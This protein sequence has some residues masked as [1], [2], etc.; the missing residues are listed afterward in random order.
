M[1]L[2][3]MIVLPPAE[4]FAQREFAVNFNYNITSGLS[5]GSF[6]EAKSDTV[7]LPRK[8]MMRSVILPGWGQYTNRQAWKIPIVYG[9]LGGLS[10]YAYFA[11]TRYAGYRAA[12][13]N[14]FEVN[15]D[16]KFGQTPGWIDPNVS[17]DFLRT[18]RD[19]YRNRR[20]FLIVTVFLAYV[21]NFVD[22]YVY[23]HMRDFDVSDDL[24][25]RIEIG[26]S[27]PVATQPTLGFTFKLN[28]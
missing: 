22:A 21:L 19:F 8:V 11:D 26:P 5:L 27:M 10:Y 18:S 4:S 15:D 23:A 14:S 3:W 7:P 25:S 12:Y 24:S 16:F 2:L 20:D 1:L 17:Q 6:E 9:L 13:Y 28:F